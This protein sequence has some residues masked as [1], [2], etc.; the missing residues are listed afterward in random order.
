MVTQYTQGTLIVDVIDPKTKELLWR[1][2]GIAAVSE[3]E[4]V[5]EQDL[6]KTV[7]AIVDK[8]PAASGKVALAQ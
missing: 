4:Q 5:Y 8:F 3:N 2:Q 6:Q 1:G 7:E